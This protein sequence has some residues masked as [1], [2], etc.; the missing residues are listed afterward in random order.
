VVASTTVASLYHA[1]RTISALLDAGR[2]PEKLRLVVN[3]LPGGA[4]M[5]ETTLK[6][7]FGTPLSTLIPECCG[8]LRE[9]MTKASLPGV[10]TKY[11]QAVTSLARAVAGLP[12]QKLRPSPFSQLLSLGGL[13]RKGAE[14]KGSAAPAAFAASGGSGSSNDRTE[15]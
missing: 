9:A 13:L 3:V 8:E 11:R 14:P 6:Q 5:G 7:M 2:E 15:R 4:E 10:E 12:E 1:K